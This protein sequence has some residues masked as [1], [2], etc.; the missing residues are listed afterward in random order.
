[1][2]AF[3]LV[4]PLNSVNNKPLTKATS[5]VTTKGMSLDFSVT[6]GALEVSGA[7]TDQNQVLWIAQETIASTD[8]RVDVLGTE[9]RDGDQYLVDLVN[10][11][12]AAHNG[13]RMF[14]AAGGLTINNTGTDAPAGVFE[15]VSPV[16]VN[17]ARQGLF[18]KV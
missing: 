16:G 14:M 18:R 3:V 2:C 11:S 15:Q 1:M 6:T 5:L 7:A 10:N 4:T 13:Q 9:M 8:N 12:N 17:T